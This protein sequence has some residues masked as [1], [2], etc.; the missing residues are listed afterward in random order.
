M[1]L[2]AEGKR[3][4]VD[5]AIRGT[6]VVLEGLD[7]VEVGA[8]A[9]GEAVLAVE[10]ELG[11]D[12]RVLTPAVHVEGRLGEH[13]R[14]GVRH[15]GGQV[16]AASLRT[17]RK[18]RAGVGLVLL[19]GSGRAVR[20]TGHVEEARGHDEIARGHLRRATKRVDRVGEGVDGVR[21][22]ERLGAQRLEERLRVVEGRAVVDVGI[23]LDNPDELLARV[24]EV[25]LDLVGGRSH[26]LVT[27]ELHLLNEVLVRVL[28]HL[29]AL[30]RVEEDI[31]DVE[32]SRHQGLLVR[33]RGRH[34]AARVGGREGLHGPQA[35][36]DRADIQVDLD[37]VVL[38]SDERQRKSRVLAEPEQQRNVEG[39][40]REGVARGAHLGRSRRGR[41]RARD[42]R[43]RGVRDVGKLGR[44]TNHLEVAALLLRR[45]GELVPDVHPVTVLAVNALATNLHLNLG[46]ELLA[47]E[48]EPAGVDAV[49][50]DTHRAAQHGLVDLREGHLEVRAVAQITV[51]G[52]R[53]RHTAT[54]VGLTREGL[55]DGFHRKVRVASV[56]HLP[57]RNFRRTRE[58]H[59]LR[60]ISNKLKQTTSHCLY[61]E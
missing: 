60:T 51:T 8:L 29:A 3:V 21:V 58:E 7:H 55:F 26:G 9:L 23:R 45:E 57:E 36:A 43:E 22:V 20:G 40:L 13:K 31:V 52:D 28:G 46:D 48:V 41:A 59:V 30:I 25:E 42:G 61:I 47:N 32:G 44:V 4:D 6:G 49:T 37:L 27:R 5:A 50:V 39:G 17:E 11:R 16:R 54:E 53:A 33:D 14:A 35:L 10:L 2:G 12:H 15:I 24:V 19:S 34:R 1:L 56:R 38:Q 18:V